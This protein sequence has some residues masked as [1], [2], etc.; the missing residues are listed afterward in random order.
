MYYKKISDSHGAGCACEL[1]I[2]W[3][4]KDFS[5]KNNSDGYIVQKFKRTL[6]EDSNLNIEEYKDISYY[7]LWEVKDGSIVFEHV[8][9]EYK[10]HTKEEHE[11]DDSDMVLKDVNF[12]LILM[13]IY[14][15]NMK[16]LI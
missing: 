7:E 16:V 13:M 15:M 2:K 8:C 1:K 6:S 11:S 5:N 9:F 10:K 3:I 14:Q 4:V 12:I